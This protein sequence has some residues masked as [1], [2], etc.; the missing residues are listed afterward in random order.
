MAIS[1]VTQVC[2][3]QCFNLY[4]ELITFDGAE[5]LEVE[6]FNKLSPKQFADLLYG[7]CEERAEAAESDQ[8]NRILISQAVLPYSVTWD[9]LYDVA[10][11]LVWEQ[12]H[13]S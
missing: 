8:A 1:E 13:A 10:R 2:K 4:N 12:N 6:E 11:D 5:A 7:I 3:I 9:R